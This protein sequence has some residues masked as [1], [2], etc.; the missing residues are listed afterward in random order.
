MSDMV[1]VVFFIPEIPWLAG[2]IKIIRLNSKCPI[3]CYMFTV[4]SHLNW[5]FMYHIKGATKPF[6]KGKV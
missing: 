4:R 1:L 6:T 3:G 2:Q 5:L